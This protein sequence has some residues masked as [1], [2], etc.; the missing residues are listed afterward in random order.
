M[1][2]QDEN[3][4]ETGRN[5]NYNEG[6]GGNL[7]QEGKENYEDEQ[8]PDQFHQNSNEMGANDNFPETRNDNSFHV[9]KMIDEFSK[10]QQFEENE[11]RI[12][13]KVNQ[14]LEQ[15]GYSITTLYKYTFMMNKILLL[16]TFTEF[17]FQRF[18][19]V[20]LFLSI[21]I[22]FIESKIFSHKHLY[23]WLLVLLGSFLLDAL[24][25]L[26]ISPVRIYLK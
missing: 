12:S 8:I 16:T 1:Y 14:F 25:L 4:E 6:L 2:N 23:K 21:V 15:K 18:D 24:V 9:D 11:K 20:T 3:Q 5:Y 17:L 7:A 22:I 13:E 10:N 26:D 19:V